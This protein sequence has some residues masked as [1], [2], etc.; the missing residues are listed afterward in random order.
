[1]RKFTTLIPML[2]LLLLGACSRPDQVRLAASSAAPVVSDFRGA[3][4]ALEKRMFLQLKALDIARAS[5]ASMAAANDA[6]LARA[7]LQIEI[8]D[9]AEKRKANLKALTADGETVRAD[10]LM[11]AQSATTPALPE[12]R[13]SV[14][15]VDRMISG[16]SAMARERHWSFDDTWRFVQAVES[17][18]QR[19]AADD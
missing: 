9:N 17:E 8:G 13:V 4:P 14:V 15:E 1:M 11:L 18:R 16:L 10:P 19:I 3:L 6:M 2:S 12:N 5:Q 7:R